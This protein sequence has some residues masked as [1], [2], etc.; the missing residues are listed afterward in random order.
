MFIE[1]ESL[2]TISIISTRNPITWRMWGVQWYPKPPK[3]T[4]DILAFLSYLPCPFSKPFLLLVVSCWVLL[5]KLKNT[6]HCHPQ[7]PLHPGKC[8]PLCFPIL[9]A[10]RDEMMLTTSVVLGLTLPSILVSLWPW[11]AGCTACDE[12]CS[13]IL[14]AAFPSFPCLCLPDVINHICDRPQ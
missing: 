9:D 4:P 2:V 10:L 11:A 3:L 12:C 1:I 8:L 6:L 5:L 7:Q 13:N 14:C